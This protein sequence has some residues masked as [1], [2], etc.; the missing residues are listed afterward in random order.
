[1]KIS[2]LQIG[3]LFD[4]IF[5]KYP[6]DKIALFAKDQYCTCRNLL[7]GCLNGN[8]TISI[9]KPHNMGRIMDDI[10]VDG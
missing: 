2:D 3:C 7:P 1:M 9:H 6:K 4:L 8:K 5:S 10:P